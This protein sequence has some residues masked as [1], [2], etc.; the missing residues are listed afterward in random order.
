MMSLRVGFIIRL[1]R[2]GAKT[3]WVV[4]DPSLGC[5][6]ISAIGKL[7]DI[8]TEGSLDRFS[9]KGVW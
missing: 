1:D 4:T 3:G 9:E 7:L 8:E 6:P 2:R 5:L